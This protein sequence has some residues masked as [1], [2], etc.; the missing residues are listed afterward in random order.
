[1]PVPAQPK[2]PPGYDVHKAGEKMEPEHKGDHVAEIGTRFQTAKQCST[3]S[4]NSHNTEHDCSDCHPVH[5]TICIHEITC[6][7]KPL[8]KT[9]IN[10]ARTSLVSSLSAVL[11]KQSR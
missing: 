5:Y 9:T 2:T 1:G 10:R 11:L 7:R 8:R 3:T 6:P 4:Q